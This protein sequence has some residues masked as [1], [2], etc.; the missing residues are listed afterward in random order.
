MN[1]FN[2]NMDLDDRKELMFY[3]RIVEKSKNRY[4]TNLKL[5]LVKSSYLEDLV[6]GFEFKCKGKDI[7]VYL[8]ED[9]ACFVIEGDMNEPH[10]VD[11]Y[12]IEKLLD[13]TK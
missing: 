11:K 9:N 13:N 7:K 10:E 8:D 3:Y 6:P 1:F 4:V 5:G 12:D 2:E